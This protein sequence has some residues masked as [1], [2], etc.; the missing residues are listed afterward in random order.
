[1][2]PPPAARPR[3][4]WPPCAPRRRPVAGRCCWCPRS[5]SPC[6]SSTGCGT[7]WAATRC[8]STAA[9]RTVSVPTSGVAC[10]R[11]PRRW[12]SAPGWRCWRPSPRWVSSSS[13]RSTTRPTSPTARR[14]TRPATWP[15]RWVAWP[16]RRSCLAAP[17]PTWSA[18]AARAGASW[19]CC[20]CPTGRSVSACR[21]RSSTCAPSWRPAIGDCCPSRWPT[22]CG[23][24]TTRPA[25]GPSWS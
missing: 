7:T 1:M 22:R 4:T 10:E 6:R 21:S 18:S 2:A 15:W 12:W 3:C 8:C 13:T 11:T 17:R 14:A 5:P 20:R 24:S 9:S 25:T 16:A 23:R 19:S